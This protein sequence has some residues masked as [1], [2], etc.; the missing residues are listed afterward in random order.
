MQ[1]LRE[2]HSEETLKK[3]YATPHDHAIYGRG[4]GIRVAVTMNIAE[5]M[6]YQL[7]ANTVADLSCGNGA[8]AKSL[9]LN[10]TVLGDFAPGYQ[11]CGPLE[12]T[13]EQI[14]PV[15]L[16]ICSETLE[17]LDNPVEVLKQIRKKSRGLVL[18][19][20]VFNWND[21]NAEHY[22]SWSPDDVKNLLENAGWVPNIFATLDTTLFGE[23]Y[24]YG[25][26]GCK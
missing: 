12:E 25:I 21:T 17:H 11:I 2:K 8:I 20:P 26:W 1:R 19:T 15:D 4:H 5:D 22:W 14:H 3:I 9:A 18:S 10:G 24:I 13:I 7:Q 16:Y 6:A 23:P